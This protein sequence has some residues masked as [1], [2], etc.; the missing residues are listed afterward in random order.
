MVVETSRSIAHVAR[1]LNV[2]ETTLG[3]WVKEYGEAHADDEPALL[4]S[5]RARLRGLERENRELKMK[6]EFSWTR[7][8]AAGCSGRTDRPAVHGA[9]RARAPPR[10]VGGPVP[11]QLLRHGPVDGRHDQTTI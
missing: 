3:N 9:H 4:V 6:V 11:P 2:N 10:H 8:V 5:E 1:E 7:P